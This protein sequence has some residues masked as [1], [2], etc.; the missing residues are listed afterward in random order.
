MRG[1][2]GNQL[3]IYSMARVLQEKTRQPITLNYTSL[4]SHDLNMQM[5]L[6]QFNLPKNVCFEETSVLPWYAN[7]DNFII[8][9]FRHYFPEM[10][11][12]ILSKFN[13][14]LWLG[15]TYKEI[16]PNFEKDI[17]LDGFWQSEKY[18][19]EYREIIVSE[20]SILVDMQDECKRLLSVI[21]DT[22]S[23]CVSIRRGDYIS[24][25]KNKNM[26]YVCDDIYI[27][28]AI[29][30]MAQLVPNAKWIV[31]SDD[32][33]WVKANVQFPGEVFYQPYKI[34]ALETMELMKECKH[35]IISNSS[36]SWWGQYLS[37]NSNKIVVAPSKW[38]VDGRKEDII[39]EDWIKI[40]V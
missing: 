8:R 5:S 23:V 34:N 27:L 28:N 12:K 31:F 20:L 32:I 11:F 15:E 4:K 37:N 38:Y 1:R 33:E 18:F 24:V 16:Q 29:K 30:K 39:N 7:T 14:Y 19:N 40:P 10:T 3:F 21:R 17:Y 13:I 6:K 36:F 26:Y 2:M 22:E 25:P 35:F 9:F